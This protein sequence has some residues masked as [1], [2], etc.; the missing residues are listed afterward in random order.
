MADWEDI[1][2]ASEFEKDIYDGIDMA[3]SVVLPSAAPRLS[4]T[5]AGKS[6]NTR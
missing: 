2:P 1:P 4:P 5:T 3:E 6:S